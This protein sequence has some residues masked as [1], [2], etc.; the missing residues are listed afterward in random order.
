MDR[1]AAVLK[2]TMNYYNI[3]C[4]KN[5]L[6]NIRIPLSNIHFD[7]KDQDLGSK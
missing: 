3:P 6:E 5:Y 2:T 1:L 7:K 4:Q